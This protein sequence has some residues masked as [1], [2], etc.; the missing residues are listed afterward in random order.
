LENKI[1]CIVATALIGAATALLQGCGV[2]HAV[3]PTEDAGPVL[4]DDAEV[5]AREGVTVICRPRSAELLTGQNGGVFA[6]TVEPNGRPVFM[7][8]A[9]FNFGW[10]GSSLWGTLFGHESGRPYFTEWYLIADGPF[11]IFNSLPGVLHPSDEERRG[12]VSVDMS[13]WTVSPLDE[14][15]EI[16]LNTHVAD[17]E[18]GLHAITLGRYSVQ[19]ERLTFD[20]GDTHEPVPARD[21]RFVGCDSRDDQRTLVLADYAQVIVDRTWEFHPGDAV[22]RV[23]DHPALELALLNDGARE[24]TLAGFSITVHMNRILADG[25]EYP[26][27]PNFVTE[28]C[29]LFDGELRLSRGVPTV[30]NVFRFDGVNIIVPGRTGSGDQ[31]LEIR[32]DFDPSA[33]SG[34]ESARVTITSRY[35]GFRLHEPEPAIVTGTLILAQN[36]LQPPESRV[37][38]IVRR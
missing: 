10:D 35:D 32:C 21:I 7:R 13:E 5:L 28:S 14:S 18:E 3:T 4:A 23:I 34:S 8:Q 27:E 2:S 17:R 31:R 30:Q 16:R 19:L 1:M 20:Y 36:N 22:G 12:T 24:G 37:S 11:S 15:R 26:E 33:L 25:T 9:D 6:M 38:V 29:S